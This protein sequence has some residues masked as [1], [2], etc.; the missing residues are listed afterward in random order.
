MRL[1]AKVGIAS[2][3]SALAIAAPQ[4]AQAC[5]SGAQGAA[6]D[7]NTQHQTQGNQGKSALAGTRGHRWGHFISGTLV[8][9]TANQ[10]GKNTYSGSITLTPTDTGSTGHTGVTY[11]FTNAKVLFGH[12]AN[13]PAA[14][15]VVKL[16]GSD[17]RGHGHGH[18]TSSTST[19]T[20]RA[21]FIRVPHVVAP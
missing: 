11:M 5:T 18:S 15:D 3:I 21:I 2:A 17:L 8:T 10:T 14:G 20:V 19:P 6:K 9:W 16:M 4:A 12:G 7:A 13:P 1:N